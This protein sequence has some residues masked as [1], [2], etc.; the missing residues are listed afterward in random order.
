MN[1]AELREHIGKLIKSDVNSIRYQV[2]LAAKRSA[3]FVGLVMALIGIAFALR[4]GK[5]DSMA[6]TG[7]CVMVPV[8]YWLLLLAS[9]NLGW[10]GALPPLVAAWLLNA[11]FVAAGLGSVLT[12][13]N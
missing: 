13:K 8:R 3:A 10:S 4:T 2:D 6:W 9:I 12:V 1:S 5:G 7:A 11:L